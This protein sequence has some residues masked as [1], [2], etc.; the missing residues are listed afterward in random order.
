MSQTK[1]TDLILRNARL[2]DGT[3]ASS[4]YGILWCQDNLWHVRH[5]EQLYTNLSTL[6]RSTLES[7][8]RVF[9]IAS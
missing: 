7:L 3:G 2:I 8:L 1:K 9:Q 4:Q 6:D 5:K